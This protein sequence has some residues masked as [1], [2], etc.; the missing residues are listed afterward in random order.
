MKIKEIKINKFKRF[1]DL[2]ITGIP[3]TAKLIVL[4]GPNGCGKTSLF[5]AFNV[6]YQIKGFGMLGTEDSKYYV[7]KSNYN[8]IQENAYGSF[9]RNIDRTINLYYYGSTLSKGQICE[10]FYFRSA[11]RNQSNF[12]IS[13][14]SKKENPVKDRNINSKTLITTD[15][16]VSDNYNRLISSTISSLFMKENNT[17]SVE[18]L[19]KELT[20][21]IQNSLHN[22]FEDLELS[23]LGKPLENGSFYFTKGISKDFIYANLSAGEKSAF[24]LILDLIIKSSYFTDTIFCIDEPESHMHTTLQANLL[25]ELYSLIPGNSQLWISTHSMGM[26]KKAKELEEENPGTVIF[27]DFENR[28]FDNKVVMTPSGI[29][30]TMWKRFLDLALGDLSK[31]IAPKTVVFCEGNTNG[32]KYKDFDAQIYTKIFNSKYPDVCFVSIGSCSEI[33]NEGNISMKIISQALSNSKII[34]LVDRDDRNDN[35]IEEL[36]NK[37]IKVLS[38]RHIESYLLDDEILKLLCEKENKSDKYDEILSIKKAKLEDS[39]SRGNPKDDIKSASGDIYVEI[40]KILQLSH[41]GNTKD[42][43]FRDTLAPLIT[44]ETQVY[45]ELEKDIFEGIN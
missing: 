11:Y 34:K 31:L 23:S 30:S 21:K 1:T 40:K 9:F 29:D 42:A 22:V 37:D 5:E 7:K 19:R 26:L 25:K 39:I 38:R 17:K 18:E 6:W 2:T 4:V 45:K 33:E 10:K 14:L 32:R 28:D 12:V 44:P 24:D 20:G 3:E 36:K 8:D 27:L 35:E 41:S 13:S 43:F 15:A 16:T